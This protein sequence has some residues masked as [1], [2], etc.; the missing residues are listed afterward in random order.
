MRKLVLGLSLVAL[1]ACA[2]SLNPLMKSATDELLAA[3]KGGHDLAAPGSYEPLDWVVG[4][5]TV[6]RVT[7]SKGEPSISRVAVVGREDGGFWIETESQDYYQ[8]TIGKVLYAKQPR[9][10]EEALD[11]MRKM[12]SK[13]DDQ[14]AQLFDFTDDNPA[15]AFTKRLMKS[16]VE[17]VVVPRDIDAGTA[18]SVTVPAGTF[19]GCAKIPVRVKLGP[20]TKDSLSWYHPGVPLG[21]GVKGA[22]TDGEWTV[23]LLD[24]GMTGAKSKLP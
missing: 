11:A 6:S 16:A 24:F 22:S 10:A 1:G 13:T 5:W 2:P 19:R 17:G 14:E 3:A 21:G 7:N 12:I 20:I 9:T 23:E 8:R 15:M 4:Q 18:E